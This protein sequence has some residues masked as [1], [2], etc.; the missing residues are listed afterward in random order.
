[1]VFMDLY[2]SLTWHIILCLALFIYALFEEDKTYKRF[3]IIVSIIYLLFAP[4]GHEE[5]IRN[6]KTKNNK[7]VSVVVKFKEPI[8]K[9]VFSKPIDVKIIAVD[10]VKREIKLEESSHLVTHEK[11][12]FEGSYNDDTILLIL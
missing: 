8:F 10:G 11:T 2:I 7:T 1:M 4:Y 9:V 6:C 12:V 3:L 5:P